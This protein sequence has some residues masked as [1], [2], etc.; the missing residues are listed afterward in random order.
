[1]GLKKLNFLHRYYNLSESNSLGSRLLVRN[2]LELEI[3]GLL[4]SHIYVKELRF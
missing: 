1:M 4:L 2:A 3:E